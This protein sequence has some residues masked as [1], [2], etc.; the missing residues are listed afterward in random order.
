MGNLQNKNPTGEQHRKKLQ[1]SKKEDQKT[2]I[3]LGNAQILWVYRRVFHA[4]IDIQYEELIYYHRKPNPEF[5]ISKNSKSEGRKPKQVP[6][7]KVKEI[8]AQ[9]RTN[10][11][12]ECDLMIKNQYRETISI[13]IASRFLGKKKKHNRQQ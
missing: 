9:T 3:G 8:K 6:K 10:R 7:Y 4:N 13:F 1:Q 12:S 11:S 5:I 2:S